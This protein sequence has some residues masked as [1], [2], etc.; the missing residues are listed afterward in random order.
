MHQRER[1]G[2]EIAREELCWEGSST[3]NAELLA[4]GLHK[5][6]FTQRNF[7]Q[8]SFTRRRIFLHSEACTQGRKLVH[9]DDCTH[10]LYTEK[11]LHR[12]GFTHR[13]FYT[14]KSLYRVVL[15]QRSL[16]THRGF[17]IH[18]EAFYTEKSLH[19]VVFTRKSLYTQRL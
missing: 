15:A 18:R 3:E 6:A 19:R 17:Y 14:E 5:T 4:R 10:S 9:R 12:K 2:G 7:T 16:H 8:R 1:T 13:S 11:F